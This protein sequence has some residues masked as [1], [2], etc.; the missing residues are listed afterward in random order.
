MCSHYPTLAGWGAFVQKPSTTLNSS[1]YW[2]LG[3]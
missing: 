1:D 3:N 2:L